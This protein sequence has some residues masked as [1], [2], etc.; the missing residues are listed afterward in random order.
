MFIIFSICFLHWTGS[1]PRAGLSP[2]HLP[3]YF[4]AQRRPSTRSGRWVNKGKHFV[5]LKHGL[6]EWKEKEANPWMD[7]D[8]STGFRVCFLKVVSMSVCMATNI[9][10]HMCV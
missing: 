3:M 10:L 4:L 9:C 5:H 6:W 1:L 8:V 2:I 7:E